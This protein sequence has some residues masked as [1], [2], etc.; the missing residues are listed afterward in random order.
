M[1]FQVEKEAYYQHL[2]GLGAACNDNYLDLQALNFHKKSAVT[3][4]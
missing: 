1:T 2:S 4:I 3:A